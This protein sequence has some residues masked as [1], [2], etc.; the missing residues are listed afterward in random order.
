MKP[1]ASTLFAAGASLAAM[2]AIATGLVL[3]GPPGQARL[4]RLDQQRLQALQTL[5]NAIGAY[6]HAHGAL[7]GSLGQLA[8]AQGGLSGP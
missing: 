8:Q 2:A 1:A 6:H 7:P 4:Q 3:V 5:S